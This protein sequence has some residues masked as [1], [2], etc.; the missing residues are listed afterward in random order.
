V[1]QLKL[2]SMTRWVLLGVITTMFGMLPS[3]A[4][5]VEAS[6]KQLSVAFHGYVESNWILRDTTGWQDEFM[7]PTEGV[8]QRTTLKFDLDIHP[9]WK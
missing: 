5:A 1:N 6:Y 7:Y 9:G 8:Q 3:E 4:K 2:N